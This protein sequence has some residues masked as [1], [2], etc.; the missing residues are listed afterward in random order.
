[1]LY[2]LPFV[3]SCKSQG[4][5]AGLFSKFYE[6]PVMEA[7]TVVRNAVIDLFGDRFVQMLLSWDLTMQDV[8]SLSPLFSQ[9]FCLFLN[10]M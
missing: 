10:D 7:E 4:Q 6:A 2:E 3:H 1:M 8:I 5:G 9:L